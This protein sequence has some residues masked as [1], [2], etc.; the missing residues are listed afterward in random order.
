MPSDWR[1]SKMFLTVLAN[2][3]CD[4]AVER[5]VALRDGEPAAAKMRQEAAISEHNR[6]V[7]DL[8]EQGRPEALNKM[9]VSIVEENHDDRD[10]N[11]AVAEGF[12][13]IAGA[14]PDGSPPPAAAAKARR[15]RAA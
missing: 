3:W 15:K 13:V 11:P 7:S 6:L 1:R 12:R 14:Q 2:P 9:E 10:E 8:L 4:V 5:Y